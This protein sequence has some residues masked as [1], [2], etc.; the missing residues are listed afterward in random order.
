MFNL[1]YLIQFSWFK[2][3]Y[4]KLYNYKFGN[5]AIEQCKANDK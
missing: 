4:L 5:S 2:L 3:I 1:I